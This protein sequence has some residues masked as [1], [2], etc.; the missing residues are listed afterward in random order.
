MYKFT[1]KEKM[2][3]LKALRSADT[4][5]VC[6]RYRV[7]RTTLWR[8]R[9]RYDGTIESL[10]PKFSRKGMRHPNEQTDEEKKN[11]H[12][13]LRRNPNIG[14]NELYGKL[15]RKYEYRRNPVTLYRYLKR[16]NVYKT[17]K[18]EPY[19]PKPYDTPLILGVKWQMDVKHVP[20]ECYLGNGEREQYYQYT[21]IEEASRKRFIYAYKDIGQQ[22]T[23]DSF[24]GRSSFLVIGP[25]S[26]RPIMAANLRFAI[27]RPRTAAYICLI[28][29]A[30]ISAYNINLHGRERRGITAKSNVPTG[31]IM[32]DF[33]DFCG[34]I[35]LK[36]CKSK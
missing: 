21:M 32:S 35:R 18:R 17:P 12:N 3:A 6:R 28:N 19:K 15:Y 1:A 36:T 24:C 7:N 16:C 27:L 33:I 14:L 10:A 29:Y 11:I 31:M 23:V 25:K 26:Y 5:T 30:T 4:L 9:R 8:W 34:F 20:L 13:L 22:S 2:Y